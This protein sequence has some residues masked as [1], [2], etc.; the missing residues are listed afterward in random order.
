[1]QDELSAFFLLGLI[2]VRLA[3]EVSAQVIRIP[4]PCDTSHHRHMITVLPPRAN[5]INR[6]GV[7][8]VHND[9][10]RTDVDARRPGSAGLENQLACRLRRC[11]R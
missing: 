2:P 1:V 7:N 4:A 10:I 3:V 9:G 8:A 11:L 5:A 6:A